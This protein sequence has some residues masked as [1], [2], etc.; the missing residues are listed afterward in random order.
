MQ[1]V[2][3]KYKINPQLP[4]TIKEKPQLS[5]GTVL[6]ATEK[7]LDVHPFEESKILLVK[8]DGRTGFRGLIINKHISWDSL[9]ELGEGSFDFLK[10][11]T[12]SFGGPVMMR[13]MPLSALTHKFIE[14][15]SLEILPN[16]YYMDQMNSPSLLEE[17]RGGNHSVS[18]F[19][20]FLGYS[21]WGWEQ[22]FNEIAQGA[23]NVSKG[24]FEHSEWPW[25]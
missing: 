15:Q 11:A 10:E 6:S 2:A 25:R 3:A 16:I 20:F 17:I 18:D 21:S 14:G 9:E 4:S 22:L 8:V 24:E 7:L 23:W 12:L 5:V 1:N 13:G 19:W